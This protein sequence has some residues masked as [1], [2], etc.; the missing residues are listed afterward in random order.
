MSIA[1]TEAPTIAAISTEAAAPAAPAP[2]LVY[3]ADGE[4]YAFGG[5]GEL[6]DELV[7][8][9]SSAEL[10]G[11]QYFVGEEVRYTA[12]QFFTGAADCLIDRARDAAFDEADE[13]A[14]DFAANVPK[15]AMDELDALVK[16]WADKHIPC[17]FATVK[18]VRQMAITAE[19]LT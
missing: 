5:L 8:D 16:A 4:H 15:E 1:T 13:W 2:E 11:Q 3:S 17:T 9:F 12:G 14:G 19:D 6:L 10:L 18:N 7:G